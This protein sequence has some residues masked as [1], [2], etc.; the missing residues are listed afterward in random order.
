MRHNELPV[1]TRTFPHDGW[2]TSTRCGPNGGNC[3]QVNRA[4][5]EVVAVRDGKRPADE[6]LVFARVRWHAFLAAA[7]AGRFDG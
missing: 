1:T 5:H 3:V 2:A 7:R 6:G 4:L